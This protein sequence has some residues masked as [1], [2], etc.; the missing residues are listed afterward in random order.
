MAKVGRPVTKY[1]EEYKADI[2]EKFEKYIDDNDIPIVAE[3]AYKNNIVRERLYE[4]PELAYTIKRCI[5]KKETNLEKG[6][7]SGKL[8]AAMGIFS[9]K[10][11]GWRDRQELAHSGNISDG[12]DTENKL[13]ELFEK[14]GE[15]KIEKLFKILND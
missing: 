15:G 6:V 2:L 1:T 11:L 14:E 13:K 7:L 12:S 8:N 9:L 4:F 5:G 3:F 10:Q